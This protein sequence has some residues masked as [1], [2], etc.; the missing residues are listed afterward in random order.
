MR[1]DFINI[2]AS[3]SNCSSATQRYTIRYE[4]DTPCSDYA[5]SVPVKLRP[6]E[7]SVAFP[8]FVP[9]FACPGGYMIT[10]K[11]FSGATLL[12]SSSAMVMVV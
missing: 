11:V 6:G 7:Y 12:A 9:R 3:I 1:G 5:F 2:A 4:L 8:F 10:V